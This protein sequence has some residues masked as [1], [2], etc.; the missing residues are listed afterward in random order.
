MW[1]RKRFAAVHK[2][3]R[4][5]SGNERFGGR[6]ELLT[7][8]CDVEQIAEWHPQ[9]FL[10]SQIVA[11][12]AILEEYSI[13]PARFAIACKGIDLVSIGQ[14]KACALEVGWSA[15]TASNAERLRM[16]LQR[17]PLVEAAATAIALILVHELTELGQIDVTKYGDR[18][19]FRSL[20]QQCML[21]ISGTESIAE[22]SAVTN[23]K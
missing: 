11:C 22:L 9:L 13:T 12:V 17:N 10:D 8:R 18:A 20:S 2:T 4:A 7:I 23:T 1:E 5:V 15:E 14:V 16:T 6:I 3:L 19:D 21:E